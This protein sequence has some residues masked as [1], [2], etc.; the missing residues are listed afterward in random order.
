[1]ENYKNVNLNRD[2]YKAKG[3]FCAQ[4]ERMDPSAQY[5]HTELEGYD[6]FQRQLKRY[7]IKVSGKQSDSLQKF[8]AS[9]GSAALF[10]EYVARAVGQ[11]VEETPVLEEICAAHTIIDAMDYRSMVSKPEE[12]AS[13]VEEG[14]F[15]PETT[16]RLKDSLV[17]LKKRGRLLSASYESMK[18]QK[19]DLFTVVL[20]QI[21]C[22]IG[23]AQ[24]RDAV[25]VL[26]NGDGSG[27]AAEVVSLAEPENLT[28]QDLLNLWNSFGEYQM[29]VML[30]SPDMMLKLLQIPEL[31][32]PNTGLN[33]QGTGCLTTPLG[34]K[35]IRSA[36]VPEGK[37]VGLDKRFALEMV[38]AGGVSVEYDKLIDCQLERAAVTATTG[39]S[40]LFPDA[41]KVLA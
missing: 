35:V 26:I 30:V 10:P 17:H 14:A 13:V 4:L 18:Y 40:K 28:Y 34:A 24:L 39:F 27:D 8:F 21:G 11:G 23:R 3:G 20:K 2:L 25:D 9:S 31:Q 5:R 15:I 1:M 7:D 22:S 41:V 32:D 36:A 16:I 12:E 33:F 19:I 37:I 6:A 38:S 29:N